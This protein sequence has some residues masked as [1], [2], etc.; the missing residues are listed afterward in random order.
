MD[1]DVTKRLLW[2]GLLAGIGAL[3]SIATTRLAAVIW[4][5]AFGEDPPE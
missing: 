5:R 1:N 4:R 2:S 3:A